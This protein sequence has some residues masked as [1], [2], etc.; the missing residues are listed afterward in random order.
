[1]KTSDGA[2]IHVGQTYLARASKG[3][4]PK[5]G[6]IKVTIVSIDEGNDTAIVNARAKDFGSPVLGSKDLKVWKTQHVIPPMDESEL[7]QAVGRRMVETFKSVVPDK[8][9][10]FDYVKGE[11]VFYS[12]RE[13]KQRAQNVQDSNGLVKTVWGLGETFFYLYDKKKGRYEMIAEAYDV[14]FSK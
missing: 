12:N 11:F 2:L 8:A 4:V 13:W 1:L 3:V 10:G 5:T 7:T 9:T 14:G 6:W